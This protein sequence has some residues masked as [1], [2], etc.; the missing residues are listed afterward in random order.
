MFYNTFFVLK[1]RTFRYL[2]GWLFFCCLIIES[3][4]FW[5]KVRQ[6]EMSLQRM[7][8]GQ[9]THIDRVLWSNYFGV[10]EVSGQWF[11]GIWR[12][13]SCFFK[14]HRSGWL[15]PCWISHAPIFF[16][17]PSQEKRISTS[18]FSSLILE[19]KGVQQRDWHVTSVSRTFSGKIP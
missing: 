3:K 18:S 19:M 6:A 14:G 9:Q 13:C 12:S 7:F 8:F 4:S 5:V 16:Q 1:V 11:A 15:L 17:N 10:L 2:W